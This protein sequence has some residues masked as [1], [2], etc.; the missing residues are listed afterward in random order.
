MKKV[1]LFLL[2]I[3]TVFKVSALE[4]TPNATKAI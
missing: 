3:L 4:V 1:L 2:I